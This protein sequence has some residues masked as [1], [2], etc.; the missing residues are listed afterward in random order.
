MMFSGALDDAHGHSSL[1]YTICVRFLTI[2]NI[3]IHFSREKLT[4]KTNFQVHLVNILLKLTEKHFNFSQTVLIFRAFFVSLNSV[5]IMKLT[6][7]M[8]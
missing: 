2:D 7:Q 5:F 6:F 8:L 1:F 3:L 4:G